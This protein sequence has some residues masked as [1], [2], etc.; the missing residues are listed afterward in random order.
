MKNGFKNSSNGRMLRSPADGNAHVL[1]V[2][3]ASH[4]RDALPAAMI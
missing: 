2:R 3:S 1:K 4:P